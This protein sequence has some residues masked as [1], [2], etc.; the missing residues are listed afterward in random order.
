MLLQAHLAKNTT[1]NAQDICST[2][3]LTVALKKNYSSLQSVSGS[4]RKK[5]IIQKKNILWK[6]VHNLCCMI[7]GGWRGDHHAQNTVGLGNSER[8]LDDHISV[9]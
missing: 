8:C 1:K 9:R 5:H 2:S 7:N 6:G 4:H 3:V